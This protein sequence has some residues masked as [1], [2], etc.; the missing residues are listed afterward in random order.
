VVRLSA[1]TGAVQW[2]AS[3]GRATLGLVRGGGMIWLFNEYVDGG[4][5]L[6]GRIVGFSAS[7]TGSAPGRIINLPQDEW[8][9]PMNLSLAGGTLFHQ[10]WVRGY[11]VGYRV[12]GT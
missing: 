10:T 4:G 2:S 5:G 6:A 8:G 7:A 1:A 11:L 3:I 12:P 9:F